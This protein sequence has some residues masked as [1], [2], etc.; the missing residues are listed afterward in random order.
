MIFLVFGFTFTFSSLVFGIVYFSIAGIPSIDSIINSNGFFFEMLFPIVILG[1][2][3]IVGIT[4]IVKG[5]KKLVI[6]FST[7]TKGEECFGKIYNTY[8]SGVYINES[9]ELKADIL[10][11]I[12]SIGE[13]RVISEVIGFD[14]LKYPFGSFVKL[15]Y[16]NGDI[17]LQAVV[18]EQELPANARAE[19]EKFNLSFLGLEKTIFVN[20]VEY[21]RKDSTNN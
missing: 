18:D 17:N 8:N 21:V 4:L 2:F 3:L 12:P 16:Y 11:Y 9:P 1:I 20:G 19:F 13:T 14:R 10:V 15:K 7:N 6:D 5:F